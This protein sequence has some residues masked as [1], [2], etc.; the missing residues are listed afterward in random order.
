MLVLTRRAG[1]SILI[2]NDIEVLI[3]EVE[4]Q[5]LQIR[6]AISARDDE[7]ML[8]QSLLTSAA[9]DA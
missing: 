5:E 3:I 9:G 8:L 6:C 2:G 1:E 7:E 4:W